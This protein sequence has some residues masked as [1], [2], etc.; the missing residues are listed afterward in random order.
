MKNHKVSKNKLEEYSSKSNESS[1]D[2]AI[3]NDKKMENFRELGYKSPTSR[4]IRNIL[5]DEELANDYF[6]TW[7]YLERCPKPDYR[8]HNKHRY[9]NRRSKR[10]DRGKV[11][12]RTGDFSDD[13][14]VQRPIRNN[15]ERQKQEEQEDE[16]SDTLYDNCTGCKLKKHEGARKDRKKICCDDESAIDYDYLM[17]KY[18]NYEKKYRKKVCNDRKYGSRDIY[19]RVIGF[20]LYYH[21]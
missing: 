16:F 4:Q 17:T 13:H 18:R 5:N 12:I 14:R 1:E 20:F 21:I 2:E 8:S 7:Q 11:Q 10:G 3:E 15:R 6:K 19:K 9:A